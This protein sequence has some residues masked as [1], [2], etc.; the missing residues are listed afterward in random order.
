M[1]LPSPDRSFAAEQGR[2][3][4]DEVRPHEQAVRGYLRHQ[5]PSLETDDVVQESYLHLLRSHAAGKIASARAYFFRVARNTAI[6]FLHRRQGAISEVAVNRTEGFQL[7]DGGQ[8]A[9]AAVNAQQRL[10]LVAD[11]V[12]QLPVRCRAIIRHAVVDGLSAPEIASRLGLSESTVRV[13][14]AR[15]VKRCAEYLRE[16]GE[17]E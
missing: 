6:R 13:Q 16:R 17:R 12:D 11:A 9:A 14:L 1:S 5:F 4:A 3:L 10:E 8:D 15:G 2:W 7:I